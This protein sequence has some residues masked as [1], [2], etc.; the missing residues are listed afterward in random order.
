[1][2]EVSPVQKDDA[3][4]TYTDEQIEQAKEKLEEFLLSET[5]TLETQ[6]IAKLEA[7]E[8]EGLELA[9][10][11][12][13]SELEITKIQESFGKKRQKTRDKFDKAELDADK[14]QRDNLINAYSAFI[15]K[16]LGDEEAAAR[17]QQFKA[18]VDTYSAANKAYAKAG[19]WPGGVF[20]AATSVMYGLANVGMIEKS[21]QDMRASKKAQFGMNEIIDSPTNLLVGEGS[22]PE[23]VQVTPLQDEN[24]FG[25]E[26]GG[27]S[28]NITFT[29]NVMSQEFIEDEAIPMIKE[30]LRRGEDIGIS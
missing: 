21:I 8:A 17:I 27:S 14:K 11:A 7:K 2:V 18:I 1:M 16:F 9:R 22:G 6:A 30:S 20:P 29:G 13:A 28:V 25:P 26:G 4:I 23:L 12:G 5:E 19:G 24:R 3:P 10:I 15:G